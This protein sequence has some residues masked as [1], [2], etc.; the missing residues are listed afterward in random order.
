MRYQPACDQLTVRS[1]VECN[2]P[3]NCGRPRKR[4]TIPGRLE[5]A[6]GSP[7]LN[8]SRALTSSWRMQLQQP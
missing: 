5:T 2:A 7:P 6:P 3:C 4:Q 1:I 8:G